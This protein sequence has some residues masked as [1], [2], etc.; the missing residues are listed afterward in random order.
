MTKGEEQGWIDIKK[1]IPPDSTKEYTL[2]VEVWR[3]GKLCSTEV[4]RDSFFYNSITG[5]FTPSRDIES[6]EDYCR[7][8]HWREL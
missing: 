7:I 5:S 4:R 1:I 2:L 3:Y 6:D 8:T